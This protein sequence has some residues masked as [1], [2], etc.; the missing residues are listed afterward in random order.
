MHLT[1]LNSTFSFPFP[2][3]FQMCPI[4]DNMG[5]TLWLLSLLATTLIATS[6]CFYAPPPLVKYQ[7]FDNVAVG[8]QVSKNPSCFI[9]STWFNLG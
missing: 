4:V 9:C 7:H 3:S 1:R 6:E 2:H 8:A 5:V